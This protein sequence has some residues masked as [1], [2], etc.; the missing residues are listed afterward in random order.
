MADS[1]VSVVMATYNRS[2]Y[3]RRALDS[4][5]AQ[6]IP[7]H[8]V[9]VIDDA[10]TDE[11]PEIVASYDERVH[12]V[13]RATNGG[14]SAALNQGLPLVSGDLVWT[15]DDDDVAMPEALASHLAVFCANPGIGFSYGPFFLCDEAPD[16]G[17]AIQDVSERV[18]A[19][20][21]DV[22]HELLFRCFMYGIS[23]LVRRT[24]LESVGPYRTDLRRSQDWDMNLRISRRFPGQ[25][26]AEP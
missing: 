6:T 22:F 2:R 23:L 9:I 11:T 5:L 17:L 25:P 21:L 18:T 26:V 14:R 19:A 3:I 15:F 16:G 20:G 24:C 4:L 8:E 12:Y 7:P 10:S 13:R 1:R